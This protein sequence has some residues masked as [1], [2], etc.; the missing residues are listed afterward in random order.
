MALGNERKQ[1]AMQKTYD[2]VTMRDDK[3]FYFGDDQDI[4]LEYDEDGTDSLLIDGGNVTLADDHKLYFGTG[5]DVSIEYDEDGLDT[6]LIDGGTVTIADD[7]KLYF[8]TGQDGYIE[9]DENGTDVFALGVAVSG[10]VF[11]AGN[12]L[13]AGG[14]G[15]AKG[16]LLVDVVSGALYCNTAN[17]S[18]AVWET[19]SE[20]VF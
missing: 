14:A 5:Q 16:C 19:L 11:A 12:G 4:S 13:S 3:K 17:P 15:F 6:L 8:G 2:D 7:H 1:G 10:A 9:Y 20:V 18:S